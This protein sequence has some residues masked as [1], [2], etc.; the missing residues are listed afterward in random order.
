MFLSGDAGESRSDGGD[1][2]GCSL[3]D[4]GGRADAIQAFKHVEKLRVELRTNGF[5]PHLDAILP[6]VVIPADLERF[7][8]HHALVNVGNPAS[9]EHNVTLHAG[10]CDHGRAHSL[11][12]FAI[13]HHLKEVDLPSVRQRCKARAVAV[14]RFAFESRPLQE[15]PNAEREVIEAGLF[16]RVLF[17]KLNV[18]RRKGLA[19]VGHAS[20]F[21]VGALAIWTRINGME[22]LDLGE[23]FLV[24]AQGFAALRGKVVSTEVLSGFFN[25]PFKLAE[26]NVNHAKTVL[27]DAVGAGRKMLKTKLAFFEGV[28]ERR[29][30]ESAVRKKILVRLGVIAGVGQVFS[31]KLAAFLRPLFHLVGAA[32]LT[33]WIK[34]KPRLI[35]WHHPGHQA[36][37]HRHQRIPCRRVEKQTLARGVR[38]IDLAGDAS[39]ARSHQ[40]GDF[41]PL[42]EPRHPIRLHLLPALRELFG[43][44][45]FLGR[46]RVHRC[47]LWRFLR[48]WTRSRDCGSWSRE[49][50]PAWRQPRQ[51]GAAVEL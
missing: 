51:C 12:G 46:F 21:V 14:S 39:R 28:V 9:R 11:L 33:S 35:R 48:G 23:L 50:R 44:H 31:G 49:R 17:S 19:P 1:L 26:E 6:D 29:R 7:R 4:L 16:Q 36:A 41:L 20:D 32:K 30:A 40:V 3:V 5:L 13:H 2:L 34:S 38:Q 37:R 24:V 8:L 25:A 47:M 10:V 43:L 27:F 42:D 15:A 18:A 45:G 22:N